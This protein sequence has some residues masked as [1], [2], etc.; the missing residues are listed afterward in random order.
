[1]STRRAFLKATGALT[2]CFTLPAC[3]ADEKQGVY[4]TLR[5]ANRLTV[6]ADGSVRLL[7]GKV[8]LG[9]GISTALA[10]MAAEE[11][12]IAFER[13][14]V[15]NVDTRY[16]P[17]ESYTFSS[18][19]IQQSGPPT[20]KAAAAARESLLARAAVQL[21]TPVADLSVVDGVVFKKGLATKVDYWRLIG[22]TENEISS[23]VDQ[24]LKLVEIGRASCRERV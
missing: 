11:L 10:Q 18:I 22:D 17:D 4:G 15:V 6:S 24:E 3:A 5:A 12:D 19:S 16:S 23:P 1:M 2:V 7:L 20:R 9:Q 8:E 14:E 13:I 21:S